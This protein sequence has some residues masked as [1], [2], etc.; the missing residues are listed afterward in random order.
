TQLPPIA[1]LRR[2]GVPLAVATDCNPGTA[3]VASILA[4]MNFAALEFGLSVDECLDGVTRQ[5][6]RALGR[7]AECGVIAP[8]YWCDLAIWNVAQPAQLVL[9][10]GQRPLHARVWHGQTDQALN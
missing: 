7:A 9:S 5:A 4:A 1:L 8:G 6:A 2:A 3:P 10:L